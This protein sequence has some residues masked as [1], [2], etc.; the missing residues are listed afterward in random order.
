MVKVKDKIAPENNNIDK[1][2]KF[3]VLH[4]AKSY[5]CTQI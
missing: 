2:R 5:F 4:E 1:Y 3:N